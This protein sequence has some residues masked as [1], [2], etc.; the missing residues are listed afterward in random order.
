[1]SEMSESPIAKFAEK[2]LIGT[3]DS[4]AR[5][6]ARFVESIAA[7]AKQA[8]RNEAAKAELIENGAKFWRVNTVGEIP[9]N[10]VTV[11][12]VTTEQVQ[13]KQS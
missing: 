4:I 10:G 5:A 3:V 9:N 8:L 13:E 7:D 2:L 1:M 12:Q 11:E 6:G